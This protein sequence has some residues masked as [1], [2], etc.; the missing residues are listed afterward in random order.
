MI[1]FLS[2]YTCK[3]SNNI[4]NNNHKHHIISMVI[5]HITIIR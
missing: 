5:T 3:V 1:V 2:Y 4:L